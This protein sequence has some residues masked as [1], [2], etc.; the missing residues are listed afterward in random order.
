MSYKQSEIRNLLSEAGL[1]V[2]P[3]RVEIL[4]AI[5]TLKNH[6]T[7]EKIIE[8]IRKSN[9]NIATGTVYKVLDTLVQKNLVKRVKTDRDIM[10][11]DGITENHHHLYCSK[12]DTIEDYNDPEL[13]QL[14]SE[15][16]NKKNLKH[17]AI[18]D[19]VLQIRGTFH[20]C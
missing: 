6:P 16:F 10:R 18:E 8:H 20:K 14:L 15:Y 19:V 11:Y 1:K 3:Q 4:N 17:F 2:T 5:Y 7:A 9:P 12:C 13:D